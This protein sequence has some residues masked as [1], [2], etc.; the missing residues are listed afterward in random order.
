MK[1]TNRKLFLILLAASVVGTL[2]V[3]PYSMAL[4][5]TTGPAAKSALPLPMP[6][7]VALTVL[8]SAVLFA[9]AIAL[10]MWAGRRTGLGPRILPAAL[11]GESIGGRLRAIVA[12]SLI[13]GILAALAIIVLDVFVFRPLLEAQVGAAAEGLTRAGARPAAWKGLLASLYG[14]I[15]EELLL[16]FGLLSFFAFVGGRI[17]RTPPGPSTTAVL[18]IANFA[19]AILFGLGH[20]PATS[21]ILPLSTLVVVRALVLNGVGGIAFGYLYFTRG[22]ESAMLAH[23]TADIVLHVLFV[24]VAG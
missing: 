24:L 12:P 9:L 1:T 21:Q 18:W 5:G 13:L 7:L 10:G 11:E 15:N 23:F 17:L 20:L 2:G 22:L 16:R 4:Q 8:Q 14:G 6:A 19:A 3:L